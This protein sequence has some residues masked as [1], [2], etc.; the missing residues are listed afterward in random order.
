MKQLPMTPELSALITGAVGADVETDKITVFE[1]IALNTQPLPGKDGTIFEKAVVEPITLAQMADFIN[2]GKHIPLM[3]DHELFGAPKGRVFHAGL[4]YGEEGNYDTLELRTLFYL[5][6]T[7][8]DLIAKLNA[9]SLDEVSVSFLSTSFL[10]S[11]C[12]WDY[13]EFGTK[14]NFANKTC[15]HD[16]TIGEDGVHALLVGLNQFIEESLVARGAADNP[17]I[18]GKSQAKLAPETAYRLAAKGLEPD[19]LV[20]RASRGKEEIMDPKFVTE[21]VEAKTEVGVLTASLAAKDKEIGTL[22][23]ARE[24]AEARVTELETE[25]AAAKDAKPEDYETSKA[26]A[27]AGVAYLSEQLDHLHVA[28]GKA[29]LEGDARPKTVAALKLAIGELTDN[30]TSIL[31]V[32]GVAASARQENGKTTDGAIKPSAFTVRSRA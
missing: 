21:L 11:A 6:N 16:H 31:P 1:A 9:G 7:E 14:E 4:T 20:V 2:S 28:A 29:K 32:G 22:T 23:A 10:C 12:G 25:L 8:T 27:E 5:D 17:K 15:A 19:A 18:V 3:A 24:T 30:M 26:E 13:F